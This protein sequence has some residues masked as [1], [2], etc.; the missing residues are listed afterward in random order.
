MPSPVWDVPR[1]ERER[2][3]EGCCPEEAAPAAD[4]RPSQVAQAEELWER[5]LLLCPPEH[6][7][8]VRL[9][10]QGRPLA[11]IAEH[12]GLHPSSVR[13]ILYDLARRLADV[14]KA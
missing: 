8:I 12:T 1:W 6:R 4:P 3:L 10:R 9:R 7:D 5:M 2:S 13:R 14:Q 11:E